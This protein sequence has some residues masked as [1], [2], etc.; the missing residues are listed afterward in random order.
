MKI[1]ASRASGSDAYQRYL[2]WLQRADADVELCDL[3][4]APDVPTAVALLRDCAGLIL[5][6]GPDVA[7]DR[8]GQPEKA[9]LCG[10]ADLRRD[11]LELALI[12][13]AHEIGIPVLGICR[14]A[15]IL[16]VAYGG[17]LIADLPAAIGTSIEHRR[18]LDEDSSHDVALESG[19][20]LK[21]ISRVLD[22]TINSAHHQA[23]E[24]L[25]DPFTAAAVSPDGVVEAFEFGDATLGGKHFLLAV[26]WH[27]ERMNYDNPLSHAIAEHFTAECLAFETLLRGKRTPPRA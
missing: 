6:G 16:N 14:G 18:L 23:V 7:P 8:Y 9:P 27:P 25:A 2:P 5:T 19:T 20:V 26:Q 3:W 4:T 11:D 24:R 17:T 12:K 1:A 22:G 13:E 21:R 15:Q 10:E